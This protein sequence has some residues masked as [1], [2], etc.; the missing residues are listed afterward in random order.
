MAAERVGYQRLY[1]AAG[2][3]LQQQPECCFEF[4]DG[5][6]LNVGIYIGPRPRFGIWVTTA[7]KQLVPGET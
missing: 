4:V 3:S 2:C 6:V 5:E 1:D 7:D